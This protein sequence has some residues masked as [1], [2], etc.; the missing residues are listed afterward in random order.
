MFNPYFFVLE[1]MAERH[2]SLD[3]LEIISYFAVLN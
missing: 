1:T 3:K 2:L